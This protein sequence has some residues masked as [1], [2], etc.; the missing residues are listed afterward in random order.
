MSRAS[1]PIAWQIRLCLAQNLKNSK[2]GLRPDGIEV[3]FFAVEDVEQPFV[4]RV[5]QLRG[6]LIKCFGIDQVTAR[7]FEQARAE[8]EIALRSPLIPWVRF[9]R[10]SIRRYGARRR[11]R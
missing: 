2:P 3:L 1:F 9:Y 6:Q 5:L 8:I 11:I 10:E 7:V 4:D